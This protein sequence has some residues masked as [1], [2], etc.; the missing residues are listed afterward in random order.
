[1][2]G[3]ENTALR[4]TV[5]VLVRHQQIHGPF[6]LWIYHIFEVKAVFDSVISAQLVQNPEGDDLSLMTSTYFIFV[7]FD[8]PCSNMGFSLKSCEQSHNWSKIRDRTV[9]ASCSADWSYAP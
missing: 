6:D 9:R 2:N 5:Q 4:N 3:M 1:M 7:V 8:R